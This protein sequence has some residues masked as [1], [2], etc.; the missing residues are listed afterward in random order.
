MH[1]CVVAVEDPCS[2]E[3]G[4]DLAVCIRSL[5]LVAFVDS[6]VEVLEDSGTRLEARATSSADGKPDPVHD[7]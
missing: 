6:V 1:G 5:L 7:D 3:D 4:N 2:E